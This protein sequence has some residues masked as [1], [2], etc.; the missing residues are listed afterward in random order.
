MAR[1]DVTKR[2]G[3]GDRLPVSRRSSVFAPW[4]DDILEPYRWLD[5][6]FSRDVPLSGFEN[7]LLTPAI[8]IDETNDAYLVTADVPGVKKDD[9]K[10]ETVGNQ[11][12]ISAERRFETT[13]GRRN[14]RRERY[15]GTFQRSFTLPSGADMEQIEANYDGGVLTVKIPKGEQAKARRIEIGEQKAQAAHSGQSGQAGQ[16]GQSGQA[17][18]ASQ[19]SESHQQ[20]TRQPEE[21]PAE[22]ARH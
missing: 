9:I 15:Y 20:K 2:E 6:V 18:Q 13:E 12:T 11:L 22:G 14:E 21:P 4:F 5:D 16:A 7:R 17:G 3:R 1:G 8:D 10:I 19:A